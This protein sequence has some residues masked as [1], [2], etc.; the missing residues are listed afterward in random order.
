[1]RKAVL[2]ITL[3]LFLVPSIS[4]QGVKLG[5]GVFGGF[6]FPVGQED[7]AKGSVFGIRGKIKL[8]PIITVEPRLSFTSFGE[9]ESDEI[10]LDLDGSKV[11]SYGV[12]AVIGAPM[13]GQGFAMFGVVG[14]GFYKMKRDQ[15]FEDF[16]NLGWSAGFGF[17]IGFTPM[18]S[19]DVRG[20]AHVIPFD[21]GG[22]A[23]SVA[24]IGG[25]NYFFGM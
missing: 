6:D 3:L 8:L 15:T 1:M 19:V 11:T 7:Q 22:T 5:L 16:T 13:G 21:D 24:V 23:K 4:A 12:D 2:A 9:P 14:A 17:A 18:I 20:V 25:L 10:P